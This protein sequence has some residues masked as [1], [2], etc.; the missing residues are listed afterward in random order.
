MRE[1]WKE[2]GRGVGAEKLESPEFFWEGS[3][4]AM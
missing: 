3:G 1:G 4:A 2:P